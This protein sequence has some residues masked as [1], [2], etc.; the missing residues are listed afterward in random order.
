MTNPYV[1]AM[2]PAPLLPVDELEPE[3]LMMYL[4]GLDQISA[5]PGPLGEAA[6]ALAEQLRP[7]A[8]A[9][10]DERARRL[11]RDRDVGPL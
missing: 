4:E 9:K 2:L 3:Q 10:V 5:T 7:T 8:A 6:R 11:S 1:A